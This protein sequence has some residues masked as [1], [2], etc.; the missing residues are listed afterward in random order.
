MTSDKCCRPGFGYRQICNFLDWSDPDLA[1]NPDPDLYLQCFMEKNG[2]TYILP[3]KNFTCFRVG[4]GLDPDLV[5]EC[6]FSIGSGKK[7]LPA[8]IV[9]HCLSFSCTVKIQYV[10]VMPLYN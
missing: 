3:R 1:L 10:D 8:V 5:H 6:L 4:S 2:G 7:L 9:L